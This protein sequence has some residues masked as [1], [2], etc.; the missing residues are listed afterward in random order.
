M[1]FVACYVLITRFML[2]LFVL[3]LFPC[4]VCFAFYF[5]CSVFLYLLCIVS[6]HVYSCLFSISVQVY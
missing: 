5:V 6:P 4:F 2:L 3:C 1:S